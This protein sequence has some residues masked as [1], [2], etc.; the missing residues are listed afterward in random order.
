MCLLVYMY[1]AHMCVGKH[2]RNTHTNATLKTH[3]HRK[4]GQPFHAMVSSINRCSNI[5]FCIISLLDHIIYMEIIHGYI[6]NKNTKYGWKKT[7]VFRYLKKNSIILKTLFYIAI[8]FS[9]CQQSRLV[10]KYICRFK[11]AKLLVT[12]SL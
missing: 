6:N 4:R 1:T 8:V 12:P 3:I 5:F 2:L 11:C 9:K 10:L 7:T